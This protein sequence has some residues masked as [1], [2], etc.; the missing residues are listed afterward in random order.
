M[1]QR[2]KEKRHDGG[3]KGHEEWGRT[4]R[5]VGRRIPLASR[6]I[7]RFRMTSRHH[8]WRLADAVRVVG[9]GYHKKG[10]WK[11]A[12]EEGVAILDETKKRRP[13]E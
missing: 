6:E 2:A 5:S 7:D 4:R 8:L 1:Q 9:L 11:W 13:E 12:P 10:S 3:K